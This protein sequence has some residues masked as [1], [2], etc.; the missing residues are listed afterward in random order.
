[1]RHVSGFVSV[2]SGDTDK[3]KKIREA[4]I[5]TIS[6]VACD[7]PSGNQLLWSIFKALCTFCAYQTLSFSSNAFRALIYIESLELLQPLQPPLPPFPTPPST[8][9]A[10]EG[11]LSPLLVGS[12]DSRIQGADLLR[13]GATH[14]DASSFTILETLMNH[15][16]NIR[17]L[18]PL[19][20]K[21][22]EKWSAA[23]WKMVTWSLQDEDGTRDE[24]DEEKCYLEY[25]N[26]E[27]VDNV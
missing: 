5:F 24:E 11:P 7:S 17:A 3:A 26:V 25:P 18:P 2:Q 1:M 9:S 21:R 23:F 14:H 8:L 27:D 12:S 6:F 10:L 4:A 15:K 16:A 20:L 13:R 19:S 22:E